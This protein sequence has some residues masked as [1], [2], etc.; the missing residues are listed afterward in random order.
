MKIYELT[1][2]GHEDVNEL[3]RQ[4]FSEYSVYSCDKNETR[5]LLPYEFDDPPFDIISCQFSILIKDIEQN[6]PAGILT[7]QVCDR[8][9]I[10]DIVYI[11]RFDEEE[12]EKIKKI[13]LTKLQK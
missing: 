10:D 2:S 12:F 7:V 4:T 13:Y 6:T 5:L 3:I 9:N 11:V 8:A 1:S